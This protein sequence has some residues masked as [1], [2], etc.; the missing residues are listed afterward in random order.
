MTTTDIT[1]LGICDRC[2]H[3]AYVRAFFD[4]LTLWFCGHHFREVEVKLRVDGWH[5]DDKRDQLTGDELREQP[6][7]QLPVK[8]QY[9]GKHE[10]GP[11]Y[12]ATDPDEMKDGHGDGGI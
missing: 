1:T 10:G 12:T 8:V 9:Q 5:V 7:P 2:G 6:K 3:T 4:A 11:G